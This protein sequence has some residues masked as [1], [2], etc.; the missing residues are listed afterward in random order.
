MLRIIKVLVKRLDEEAV[1]YCFWKSTWDLPRA[2]DGDSD[3]DLLVAKGNA[4]RF[5]K[6]VSGIGFK[7][8][9]T[10][11]WRENKFSCH[12]YGIDEPTGKIIHLHVYYKLVTGGTLLKN[13]HLPLE[14]LLLKNVVTKHGVKVC[15][16]GA[17]LLVFML[18]KILEISSLFEYPFLI[19]ENDLIKEEFKNLY[20][21]S[22]FD[23][24]ILLADRY[25]PTIGSNILKRA[26]DVFTRKLFSLPA[27]WTG[28]MAARRLREF[29]IY[30]LFG[31]FSIKFFR[32]F[33]YTIEYFFSRNKGNILASG[34]AIIAIVGPEASGKSTFVAELASWLGEHFQVGKVHVGKPPPCISTWL[35]HAM[36]PVLR[37]MFPTSRTGYVEEKKWSGKKEKG[38]N[39]SL[40]FLLRCLMVAYERRK[41]LLRCYR[42][43]GKGKI[44]ICDRYPSSVVHGTDG[45]QTS[46]STFSSPIKRFLSSIEVNF[47]RQ[48]PAPD[49]VIFLNVPLDTTLKRNL[50]RDKKGPKE[51]ESYIR[52]RYKVLSKWFREDTIVKHINNSGPFEDV[53]PLVKRLVWD[54]L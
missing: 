41:L 47:Y 6:I 2:L 9:T 29:R 32:S 24:A 26:R 51:T 10:E 52:L 35:P 49:L 3:L 17:E 19:K 39:C 22:A 45:P 23:E 25:L 48:I 8:G 27:F 46:P 21:E 1:S 5:E 31:A 36:L 38:D 14:E 18:R 30:G 37:R 43:T 34:G 42:K 54:V 7:R 15:H 4:G 40:L 44:I 28:L 13:Y 53:F 12:F 50:G 11:C 16:E 33:R 20:S